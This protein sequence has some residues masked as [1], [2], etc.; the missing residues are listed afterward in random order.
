MGLPCV[1]MWK[2]KRWERKKNLKLDYMHINLISSGDQLY[3]S[4]STLC[5]KIDTLA[6]HSTAINNNIQ[7]ICHSDHILCLTKSFSFKKYTQSVT[8]KKNLHTSP[9]RWQRKW[10]VFFICKAV[11]KVPCYHGEYICKLKRK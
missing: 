6:N 3:S 4:A 9:C 8:R 5:Y 11:L 1:V 10:Q 7:I 2:G